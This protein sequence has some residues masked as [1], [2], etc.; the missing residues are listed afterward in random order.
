MMNEKNK[1]ECNDLL[2]IHE[3]MQKC[4]DATVADAPM[5]ATLVE[6]TRDGKDDMVMYMLHNLKPHALE[7]ENGGEE[8]DKQEIDT[9]VNELLNALFN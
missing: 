8:E 5:L 6:M 7:I 2:K 4:L 3:M 9:D 1:M